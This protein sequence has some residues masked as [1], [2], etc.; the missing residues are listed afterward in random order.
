MNMK[1]TTWHKLLFLFAVQFISTQA[2]AN[3]TDSCDVERNNCLQASSPQNNARCNEQFNICTLT[4]NRQKTL[5]CV[6]LGFKNHD[7]VADKEKELKE[8]T[9]GF[10][11]IIEETK[12]HFSGLCSNNNMRCEYVI[13]WEGSMYTCGGEKREPRR[14]ACCR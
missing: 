3:C 7:G 10:A 11:R 6:Y 8:I 9:G 4:C 1:V 13:D 12:P 14:V 5:G 2:L